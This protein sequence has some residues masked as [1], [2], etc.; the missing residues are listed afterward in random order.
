M[1]ANEE[2]YGKSYA[3]TEKQIPVQA[4]DIP[5]EDGID[6]ATADSDAQLG[7]YHPRGWRNSQAIFSIKNSN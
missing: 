5:V 3:T 6:A 7:T 2:S 4:D 1:S